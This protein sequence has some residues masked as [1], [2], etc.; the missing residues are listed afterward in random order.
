V[1]FLSE[2]LRKKVRRGMMVVLST[3]RKG[4]ISND[5]ASVNQCEDCQLPSVFLTFICKHWS[6]L[7]LELPDQS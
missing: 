7:E 2:A 6:L 3:Q 4:W 5:F 1:L